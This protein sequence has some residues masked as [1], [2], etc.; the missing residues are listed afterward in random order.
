MSSA[1]SI[2][3]D[4]MS[5]FKPRPLAFPSDP[6]SVT[7]DRYTNIKKEKFTMK[8]W[9]RTKLRNL[10]TE[11]IRSSPQ[12][13]SVDESVIEEE[14]TMRFTVTPA[15]G[16]IIVQVRHYDRRRDESSSRSRGRRDA[17]R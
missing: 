15:R 13:V 7:K 9:L 4:N 12:L 10:L 16:G 5:K 6:V 8:S 17:R 11:E 14:N 2:V 3:K 1:G